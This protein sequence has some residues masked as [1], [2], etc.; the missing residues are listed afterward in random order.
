MTLLYI[1]AAHKIAINVVQH[2]ITV[3]IAVVVWRRNCF[4][5]VIIQSRNEG[6]HHKS[7]CFKSLMYRWWLMHAPGYRFKIVN[8]KSVRKII[9]IPAHYIKRMCRINDFMH[10]SF[11]FDFD[12]KISFFIMGFQFVWQNKIA[13]TKRSVFQMLSRLVFIAFWRIKWRE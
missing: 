4:W 2:L 9:S 6:T 8:G 12:K 10:H 1:I 7:G 13:F 11:F 3:D 5:M